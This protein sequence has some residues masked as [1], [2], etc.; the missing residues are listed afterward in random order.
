MEKQWKMPWWRWI[1][2]YWL[3]RFRLSQYAICTMSADK[4]LHDDFHDYPDTVDGE[5]FHFTTLRCRH[6]EKEFTI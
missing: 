4:G 6:C 2:L 1:W 5:P 3:A